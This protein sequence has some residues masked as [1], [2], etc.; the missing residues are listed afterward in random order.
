MNFEIVSLELWEKSLSGYAS[1]EK[2]DGCFRIEMVTPARCR[3]I[4]SQSDWTANF[5]VSLEEILR[6]SDICFVA[7]KGSRLVHWTHATFRSTCIQ[8]INKKIQPESKSAYLY[9][10]FTA[11]DNRCL[12]I[13]SAV[14]QEACNQ[15]AMEGTKRVYIIIERHNR[16]MKKIITKVGFK[17][18]GSAKLSRFGRIKLFHCSPRMR[19]LLS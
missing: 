7:T 13:A 2:L 1:S 8:E 18:T 9:G 14:I 6:D 16:S 17:R 10:V 19:N 3:I 15:L 11:I 5:N 4:A 12:G